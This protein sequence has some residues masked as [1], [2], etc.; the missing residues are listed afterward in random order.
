VKFTCGNI[1]KMGGLVKGPLIF[2]MPPPALPYTSIYFSIFGMLFIF[3]FFLSWKFK[4]ISNENFLSM[5]IG[6]CCHGWRIRV[7][8]IT[9]AS[10][11]YL[12]NICI[13]LWLHPHMP[14]KNIIQYLFNLFKNNFP[15]YTCFLI[16]FEILQM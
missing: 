13:I 3:I 7:F 9:F 6:G 2:R 4:Q 1:F 12:L 15:F 11:V 10:F 14:A 16:V 5:R 8:Y